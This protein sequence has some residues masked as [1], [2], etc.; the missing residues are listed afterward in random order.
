MIINSNLLTN[1]LIML[2]LLCYPVLLLTVRG[3]MNAAFFL[4]LIVAVFC[5]YRAPQS[6]HKDQ[7]DAYTI[8]FAVAMASPMLAVFLSQAYHG[9]FTA[10][11][12]D[13]PSRF[14]LT[15]PIYLALRQIK[16]NSL[17]MLQYGLPL[18]AISALLVVLIL[19]DHQPYYPRAGNT[20]IFPIHFGDLAL[21]LGVLSLLAINWTSRD[22][23]HIVALKVLGLLAGLYVS[24]QSQS[25]GGWAAI[26]VILLAWPLMQ[27]NKIKIHHLLFAS[28]FIVLSAVASYYFVGVIHTRVGEI[29]TDLTAFS[30]GNTDTSLGVR[31]QLWK[32]A[33]HL[34]RENPIFGV[35][36]NGFAPMLPTLSQS[37]LI[38]KM[39]ANIGQGEVHNLIFANMARLGIFGLLSALAIFFVPLVIFMK[40]TKSDSSIKKNAALMGICL[41][42]GFFVFTLS[43]ETFNLKMVAAF[44]SLTLAVLLAIATNKT[45][46]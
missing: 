23:A 19:A 33:L 46:T 1:R 22:R 37:G 28:V 30:Q 40:A 31:L 42:L 13:G 12:Y 6:L 14:L 29:N 18:G 2:I 10:R 43:V 24:V 27:N 8:A 44:Y 34:F 35:G 45:I 4:L 15:I 32:A 5:L 26:P 17:S 9:E 16:T 7:W 36:P 20:F 3:G 11:F 38:T 21:I 41:V 25:R 39:A